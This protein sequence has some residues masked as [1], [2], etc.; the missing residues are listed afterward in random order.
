MDNV[1]IYKRGKMSLVFFNMG[2]NEMDNEEFKY[3]K[4]NFKKCF[5][6]RMNA[7]GLDKKSFCERIL[8]SENVAYNECLIHDEMV[9]FDKNLNGKDRYIPLKYISVMEKELGKKYQKEREIC[10]EL[11]YLWKLVEQSGNRDKFKPFLNI[12]DDDLFWIA[13]NLEKLLEI[14]TKNVAFLGYLSLLNDEGKSRVLNDITYVI[15]KL[16]L[17]IN[18]EEVFENNFIEKDSYRLNDRVDC[19]LEIEHCDKFWKTNSPK[20]ASA[21]TKSSLADI[22]REYR[23]MDDLENKIYSLFISYNNNRPHDISD[24]QV[25]IMTIVVLLLRHQK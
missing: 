1:A 5:M 4:D 13:N 6:D 3:Y 9:N 18:N 10:V 17:K 7:L 20:T 8:A 14:P 12:D 22:W 21:E 19:L 2:G 15:K 11:R 25:V 16:D 24:E 23:N